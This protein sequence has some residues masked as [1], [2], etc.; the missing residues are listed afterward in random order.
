M[1]PSFPRR[2]RARLA[3]LALAALAIAL[4][5]AAQERVVNVYN[6]TDYIDPYVVDRFQRETG[7]RVRYDVYDSLEVLEAKLAAGRSGYDIV[8]PTDQPTFARLVKNGALRPIDRALVPN[9]ANLDAGMMRQV[10]AAD[11]GNR[12]GAIY[13]WGTI[14]LGVN[15]SRVAALSPDA[16]RDSLSLLFDPAQAQRVRGCGIVMMDSATDVIPT[17][18]RYLGKDPNSTAA[19]DLRAVERTLLAIRPYIR[20]FA[21]GGVIEQLASGQACV[22]FGYSGDVIQAAV[23]AE[24]AGRGVKVEYVA[25]REGAQLWHDMLAIPAD[26]PNADNAHAFINFLLRPDV[27]AEISNKTQYPNAVPA[28]WPL[29]R[30]EVRN[31]P[32]IFPDEAARA[33]FFTVGPVDAATDRARSRMWARFKAG[34]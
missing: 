15:F 27:M 32:S 23:R 12:H 20:A 30:P 6:W 1:T 21:S 10:E 7:I 3:A 22:A 28:S 24:E 4:P 18:L 26:A 13:L 17:V 31:N 11:P 8:V 2:A 5:A 19:D 9:W 25:G 33:R 14:G 29:I 16:P 34:R